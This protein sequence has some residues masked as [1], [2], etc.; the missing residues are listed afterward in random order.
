VE[1]RQCGVKA[2]VCRMWSYS[3]VGLANH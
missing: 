1:H 2:S 3:S